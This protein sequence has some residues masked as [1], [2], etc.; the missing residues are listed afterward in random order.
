[1]NEHLVNNL[2]ENGLHIFDEERFSLSR[3]EI[4]FC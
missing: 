2:I 4:D 3:V 1:M